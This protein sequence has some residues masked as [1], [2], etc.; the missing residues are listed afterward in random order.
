MKSLD[1][2]FTFFRRTSGKFLGSNPKIQQ[3]EHQPY[4]RD[5]V[6]LGVDERINTMS[7]VQAVERAE[8]S[9]HSGPT[10]IS[11]S[12]SSTGAPPE[13]SRWRERDWPSGVKMKLEL[14]RL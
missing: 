4:T 12:E 2:G 7:F 6:V 13:L 10:A 9:Q 3:Q 5:E 8:Q 1:D 11:P 14:S